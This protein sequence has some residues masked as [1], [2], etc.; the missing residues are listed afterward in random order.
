MTE[1][2]SEV[3]KKLDSWFNSTDYTVI[4]YWKNLH[5]DCFYIV[6]GSTY[7]VGETL[8]FIRIFKI[9]NKWE[10]SQDHTEST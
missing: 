9:G 2:P 7:G 4:Y 6:C 3:Q 1:L 8:F 10:L 5:S